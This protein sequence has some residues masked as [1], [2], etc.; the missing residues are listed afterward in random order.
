[1]NQLNRSKETMSSAHVPFTFMSRNPKFVQGIGMFGGKTPLNLFDV[2]RNENYV[3]KIQIGSD[4]KI[5][6]TIAPPLPDKK[7]FGLRYRRMSPI[8]EIA[9]HNQDSIVTD[10]LLQMTSFSSSQ[11]ITTTS[12]V[13]RSNS[14][15]HETITEEEYGPEDDDID[16]D[17]DILNDDN[18]DDQE[19]SPIKPGFGMVKK[20]EDMDKVIKELSQ[21]VIRSRNVSTLT[22]AMA[23]NGSSALGS[24]RSSFKRNNRLRNS[25]KALKRSLTRNQGVGAVRELW[26]KTGMITNGRKLLVDSLSE[27][28][29]EKEDDDES[30]KSRKR[31]RYCKLHGKRI[32][33][34]AASSL[35]SSARS[36]S[37]SSLEESQYQMPFKPSGH[38]SQSSTDLY[39]DV[40]KSSSDSCSKKGESSRYNSHVINGLETVDLDDLDSNKRVKF[41]KD[42]VD[43]EA[44]FRPKLMYDKLPMVSRM[45]SSKSRGDIIIDIAKLNTREGYGSG[46]FGLAASA[47]AAAGKSNHQEHWEKYYGTS[48]KFSGNPGKEPL[49]HGLG[50]QRHTAG[51]RSSS[52]G[53]QTTNNNGNCPAA[54]YRTIFTSPYFDYRRTHSKVRT[55]APDERT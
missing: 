32:P 37:I 44:L 42:V 14:F 36:S 8:G 18:E 4:G 22:R 27:E 55:Y 30:K 34:T 38:R 51:S 5:G 12:S 21:A 23:I 33:A 3:S 41:R 50:P 7:V 13:S 47:A 29:D 2:A 35:S 52:G 10:S 54:D 19:S 45:G 17:I 49:R 6:Q 46:G 1:M 48:G 28:E 11:V 16:D 20:N 43:N 24:V 53:A 9:S 25:A 39:D 31:R 26:Q 15:S 40:Y